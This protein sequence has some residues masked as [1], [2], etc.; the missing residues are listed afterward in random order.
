MKKILSFITT[1]AMTAMSL[2]SCASTNPAVAYNIVDVPVDPVEG[3]KAVVA[4]EKSGDY[5]YSFKA[6]NYGNAECEVKIYDD[7]YM[8]IT[9]PQTGASFFYY[10]K[11]YGDYLEYSERKGIFGY[12]VSLTTGGVEEIVFRNL[13]FGGYKFKSI[14]DQQKNDKRYVEGYITWNTF[15]AAR[16]PDYLYF[17]EFFQFRDKKLS[18]SKDTAGNKRDLAGTLYCAISEK[19]RWRANWTLKDEAQTQTATETM[20]LTEQ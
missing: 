10:Y 6:V 17:L 15:P 12:A 9:Y 13:F 4:Y 14:S 2:M 20:N 19:P 1:L 16:Q 8:K 7:K 18:S 5:L 11:F 3:A